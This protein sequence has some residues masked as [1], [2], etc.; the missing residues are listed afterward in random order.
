MKGEILISAMQ[1]TDAA[2]VTRLLV[3]KHR[4]LDIPSPS[5]QGAV[6]QHIYGFTTSKENMGRLPSAPLNKALSLQEGGWLLESH[7]VTPFPLPL[8]T[9][10]TAWKTPPPPAARDQ[11][12]IIKESK[13][14]FKKHKAKGSQL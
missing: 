13:H 5:L 12:F 6:L 4:L 10:N 14:C 1:L 11:A 7:R 9:K 3:M 8:R 2:F